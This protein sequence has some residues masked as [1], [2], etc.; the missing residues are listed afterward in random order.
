MGKD[1]TF[2]VTKQE[3]NML[4]AIFPAN[5]YTPSRTINEAIEATPEEF[6]LRKPVQLHIQLS[7]AAVKKLS[8]VA[9]KHKLSYAA[10]IEMA[11]DYCYRKTIMDRTMKFATK[12]N[13]LLDKNEQPFHPYIERDIEDL[14]DKLLPFMVSFIDG[15]KPFMRFHESLADQTTD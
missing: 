4:A 11:L 1:F 9:K 6:F 8:K 13:T 3:R 2:R 10:L 14:L 12:A 7:D 5:D 15:G